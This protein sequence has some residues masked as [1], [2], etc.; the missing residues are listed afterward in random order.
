MRLD[1]VNLYD[2]EAQAKQ[3][4]PHNDWDT[5]DAG[6]MDMLRLSVVVI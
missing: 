1:P 4:L 3:V 2:Y 6:A 5:I